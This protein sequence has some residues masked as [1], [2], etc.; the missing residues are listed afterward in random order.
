MHLDWG[1][2]HRPTWDIALR[3]A[4]AVDWDDLDRARLE[5]EVLATGQA[6]HVIVVGSDE[7]R[8]FVLRLRVKALTRQDAARVAAAIAEAA[9]SSLGVVLGDLGHLTIQPSQT[10]RR[11]LLGGRLRRRC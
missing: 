3:F 1:H 5:K 7:P 4:T 11:G 2:D 8:A 10:G 9:A 6:R